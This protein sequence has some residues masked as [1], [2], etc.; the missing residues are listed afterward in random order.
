MTHNLLFPAL[1]LF[2]KCPLLQEHSRHRITRVSMPTL[3]KWH[4][5]QNQAFD[6]S[7]FSKKLFVLNKTDKTKSKFQISI[8]LRLCL[9]S[10]LFLEESLKWFTCSN[11]TWVFLYTT[12]STLNQSLIFQLHTL[13]MSHS[14]HLRYWLTICLH[15]STMLTMSF[16]CRQCHL[17]AHSYKNIR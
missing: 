14:F 4:Q 13:S 9:E 8:L 2:Y 1:L 6:R 5:L 10:P 11:D 3:K 12:Q 7:E 15:T 17:T 16:N